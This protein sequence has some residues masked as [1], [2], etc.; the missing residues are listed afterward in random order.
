M[1]QPKEFST[2]NNCHNMNNTNQK[3]E[4]LS[5]VVPTITSNVPPLLHLFG[6]FSKEDVRQDMIDLGLEQEYNDIFEDEEDE[7]DEE[8][9]SLQ[10]VN[11]REIKYLT[12]NLPNKQH[13][14]KP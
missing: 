11:E 10:E 3:K 13:E 2:S 5:K 8:D 4:E 7:E 9:D 12:K 14:P 6:I 1:M